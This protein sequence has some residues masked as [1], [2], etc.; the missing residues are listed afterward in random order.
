[1]IR[2]P[3]LTNLFEVKREKLETYIWEPV[4]ESTYEKR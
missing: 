3:I 1:M 4:L 2:R